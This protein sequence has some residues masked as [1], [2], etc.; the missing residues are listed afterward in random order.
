MLET[1]T[2]LSAGAV[3]AERSVSP[4]PRTAP[5]ERSGHRAL[6]LPQPL[7]GPGTAGQTARN[8]PRCVHAMAISLNGMQTRLQSYGNR[9]Y[10]GSMI[11][12]DGK[13]TQPWTS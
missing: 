1:A 3:P 11:D 13:W 7:P 9:A 5:A 4:A 10:A 8:R 2:N 6:P 12:D